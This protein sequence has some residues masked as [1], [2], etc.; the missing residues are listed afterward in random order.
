MS[1]WDKMDKKVY[2]QSEVMQELE[3]YIVDKIFKAAKYVEAQSTTSQKMKDMSDKAK[4]T[5]TSLKEVSTQIKEISKN[6]SDDGVVEENKAED[7]STCCAC[8]LADEE[9]K[10]ECEEKTEEIETESDPEDSKDSIIKELFAI[11]Y[12]AAD[13]GN[14]KLAYKI[15]R[16]ICKIEEE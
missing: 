15:E 12:L 4:Q 13:S 1:S 8:N 10:E 2:E 7:D 9:C 16:L 6:I 3:K 11:S 5:A 14:I